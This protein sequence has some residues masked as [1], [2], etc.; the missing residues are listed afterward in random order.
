MQADEWDTAGW[1]DGGG[2]AAVDTGDGMD[3]EDGVAANAHHMM[4]LVD[5]S[6]ASFGT[7]MPDPDFPNETTDAVAWSMTAILQ[8]VVSKLRT[9][10]TQKIGKRDGIGVLLYNTKLRKPMEFSSNEE[11]DQK[12]AAGKD[13]D[14]EEDD[15]DE[16]DPT[17]FGFSGPISSSCHEIIALERPGVSTVTRL[18]STQ[19]D[20]FTGE[21]EL[22]LKE[23]FCATEEESLASPSLQLA[24]E[25]AVQAFSKASCV[26]QRPAKRDIPDKKQIWILTSQDN[27]IKDDDVRGIL[28]ESTSNVH[29]NGIELLVWPVVKDPESF[30]AEI[31][32]E[33][34]LG[35]KSPCDDED[36]STSEFVSTV[37]V[38]S[39]RS[40]RAFTLPLLFPNW[41]ETG[42]TANMMLGTSIHLLASCLLIL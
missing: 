10:T 1:G 42:D 5:C 30:D 20:T 35:A 32:Y 21:C 36:N 13:D 9:V 38:L 31:F 22:N 19:E 17:P 12:P 40:R 18:K 24:L 11:T 15:E 34:V 25:A 33:D 14:D 3:E 37:E 29:E 6:P 41:R 4:I 39:K 28:K 23:E 8:A 16:D 2:D 7:E 26:K 27:P